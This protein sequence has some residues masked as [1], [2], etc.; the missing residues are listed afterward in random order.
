[1]G[2]LMASFCVGA[3]SVDFGLCQSLPAH[4]LFSQFI[5]TWLFREPL[6]LGI[7]FAG[8]GRLIDYVPESRIGQLCFDVIVAVVTALLDMM[9]HRIF[10]RGGL[11]TDILSEAGNG[12]TIHTWM[13]IACYVV[14]GLLLWRLYFMDSSDKKVR[15]LAGRCERIPD[16]DRWRLSGPHQRT[17]ESC[18]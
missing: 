2:V 7:I 15:K 16:H 18:Q 13:A 11:I 3:S 14:S 4:K 5:R 1:M 12:M 9:L 8:V 10:S 6:C 17:P